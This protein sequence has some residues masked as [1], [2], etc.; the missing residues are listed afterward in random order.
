MTKEQKITSRNNRQQAEKFFNLQQGYVLHH[1]D[2]TWKL[3]DG[4]RQY[5]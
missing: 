4:I 5:Y 2:P 3:V 1:I